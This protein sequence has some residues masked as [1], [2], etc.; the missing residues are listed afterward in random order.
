MN[1][2]ASCQGLTI[3]VHFEYADALHGCDR[4]A[5][6]SYPG[7][8]GAASVQHAVAS[9]LRLRPTACVLKLTSIYGEL[10]ALAP[11]GMAV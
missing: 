1:I 8:H 5:H 10:I 2:P 11:A 9:V 6:L 3:G 4:L 7:S